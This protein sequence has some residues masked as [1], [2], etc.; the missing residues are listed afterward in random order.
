[1]TDNQFKEMFR[2]VSQTANKVQEIGIKIDNLEQG[3]TSLQQGQTSLQQGQTS[4][5]QGQEALQ[6][7]QEALWQGQEA[8]QRSHDELR[9]EFEEFRGETRD[10]FERLG[11]EPGKQARVVK[12]LTKDLTETRAQVDELNERVERLEHKDAA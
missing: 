2:M 12:I 7:G 10:N 1:M 5:Q 8:L 3:Q 4:L 6:Q 9:Q 11:V